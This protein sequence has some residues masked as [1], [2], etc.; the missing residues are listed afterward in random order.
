MNA[1]AVS[2]S[3]PPSPRCVPPQQAEGRLGGVQIAVATFA[4]LALGTFTHAQPA[5]STPAPDI[6]SARTSTP[7]QQPATLTATLDRPS[8]TI[9]DPITLTIELRLAPHATI[10]GPFDLTPEPVVG[11]SLGDLIVSSIRRDPPALDTTGLLHRWVILLEPQ[12]PGDATIPA[13]SIASQG[14]INATS[15]LTIRIDSVLD[16]AADF[17]AGQIRPPL[18]PI[19]PTPRP[20]P[21]AWL[22]A[23]IIATAIM[24]LGATAFLATRPTPKRRIRR[25]FT[26]LHETARA[27]ARAQLTSDADRALASADLIREAAALTLGPSARAATAHE[28]GPRLSSLLPPATSAQLAPLLTW[29]ESRRYGGSLEPPPAPPDLATV[30][31]ALERAALDALT[32]G[33][34]PA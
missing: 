24:A 16:P 13:L 17:S 10:T 2:S 18:D 11:Q 34:R 8:A 29:A 31:L 15:P 14:A 21:G 25:A 27:L 30:T 9:I 28:L 7:G 22:L 33:A 4:A 3:I 12:I 6:T 20:G 5:A 19:P 26:P 1:P 32:P 23:P